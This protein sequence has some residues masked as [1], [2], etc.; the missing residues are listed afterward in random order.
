MKMMKAAIKEQPIRNG[1]RIAEVPMPSVNDD[2]VLIKIKSAS[3]CGTDVHI[4]NWD[5][6]AASNIKLP[7]RFGHEFVGVVE[8]VGTKVDTIKPGDV[9]SAEGHI[10]CNECYL[11]KTGHRHVCRNMKSLG[12]TREG[13]FAD[14][15]SIRAM[16]VWKMD[17]NINVEVAS[18]MDPFGNAVQTVFA[19]NV[20]SKSVLITGCGPIGLMAIQV[21]KALGAYPII[22]VEHN[23]PYRLKMAKD[24]GADY[25]FLDD[26]DVTKEVK[27]LTYGEGADVALEFSGAGDA[28]KTCVNA[29]KNSGKIVILG[30]YKKEP[31]LHVNDIVL[32]GIEVQGITGRLIWDTWYQAT[33]LLKSGKVRLEPLI[34]HK[35]KFEDIHEAFEVA[36]S[37]QAGKVVLKMD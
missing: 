24:M 36:S 31:P 37:G 10:W 13:I 23:N 29:V 16:N 14:Y 20:S 30:V 18:L 34:T 8:K 26:V 4:Y 3:I 28:L 22:A 21:A 9:V 6:W 5:E 12:I 1:V 11:C 27:E 25:T 35:F 15:V 19:G 32:R 17:S 33:S 7:L 2:D